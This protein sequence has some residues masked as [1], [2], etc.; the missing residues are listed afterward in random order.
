MND[1]LTPKK[2]VNILIE[3][4]DRFISEYSSDME[5]W[6][7]INMLKEKRDQLLYW[8]EDDKE[9]KFSQEFEDCSKE[10]EGLE[11]QMSIS[12]LAQYKN[13]KQAVASHKVAKKYWLK[14]L[15]ELS[16]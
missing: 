4:H 5:R 12:S 9:G 7:R 1:D 10:L 3:K 11:D 16:S 2:I 14:A 13:N 6:E 8:I 15:K